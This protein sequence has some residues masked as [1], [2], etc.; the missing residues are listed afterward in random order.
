[1]EFKRNGGNEWVGQYI[2]DS[3]NHIYSGSLTDFNGSTSANN[4]SGSSS[5]SSGSSSSSSSSSSNDSKSKST[6]NNN[7]S[8]SS[9]SSSSSNRSSDGD[10][11]R[12]NTDYIPHNSSESIS[13]FNLSLA[14]RVLAAAAS[15][16]QYVMESTHFLQ[17]EDSHAAVRMSGNEEGKD[18]EAKNEE[19]S[20]LLTCDGK[21]KFESLCRLMRRADSSVAHATL[22]LLMRILKAL[23]LS[24]EEVEV[25][26][27]DPAELLEDQG[28]ALLEMLGPKT[29]GVDEKL[30]T[31]RNVPDPEPFL[32]EYSG[33]IFLKYLLES[34]DQR[35]E[36]S[37]SDKN[38]MAVES[39]RSNENKESYEEYL[40]IALDALSA[41]ISESPDYF[42]KKEI[43]TT[44]L[45]LESMERRKTRMARL[46]LVKRRAKAHATGAVDEGENC[47]DKILKREDRTWKKGKEGYKRQGRQRTGRVTRGKGKERETQGKNET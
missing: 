33:R 18:E 5:G 16:V 26:T 42:G 15:H 6:N 31:K 21:L 23:P 3:V 8:S 29:T 30:K 14:V 40:P 10:T 47:M 19:E 12:N 37:Q 13:L 32:S 7:R 20:S 38:K 44:D 25:P 43:E 17:K 34:V 27:I 36:M 4:D 9:S 24:H 2:S 22:S 41:F 39:N 35:N 11:T 1:M 45:R 28:K 46:R